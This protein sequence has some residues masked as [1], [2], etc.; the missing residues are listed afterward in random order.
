MIM[1]QKKEK[2]KKPFIKVNKLQIQLNRSQ[3]EEIE[4]YGLLF[5]ANH[6]TA[7]Y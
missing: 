5:A 6:Y 2:Y 1:A 7:G 4:K 3:F